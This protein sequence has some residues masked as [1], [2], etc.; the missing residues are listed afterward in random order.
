MNK[1]KLLIISGPSAGAGKDTLRTMFLQHHPDWNQPPSIT[2]RQSRPG[3]LQTKQMSF[4]SQRKFKQWQKEGKF[5]ETD[6]HADHWYGTLRNPVEELLGQGKNVLL[7]IDVNGA[8]EVKRQKPEAVLVFIKSENAQVLEARI[9]ARGSETE[10]QI[11]KR[12]K[13]AEHELTFVSQF[14][15]IIIN[16][17]NKQN[18]ALAA[19]E[20]IVL[21]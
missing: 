16:A 9:R 2:T 17:T 4:V 6:F 12:L 7:R 20:A 10:K 13:L 1:G 8:L 3:E 18:E 19:L 14:D 21:N 5:L 15:H 11:Q